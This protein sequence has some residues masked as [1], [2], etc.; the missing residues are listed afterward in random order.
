M[1][2]QKLSNSCTTMLYSRLHHSVLALSETVSVYLRQTRGV[3][4]R[5]RI[6]SNCCL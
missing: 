1:L 3:R 6:K 4:Q 5:M 2:F